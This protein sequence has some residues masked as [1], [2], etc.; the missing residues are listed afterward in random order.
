MKDLS[1]CCPGVDLLA[2][3]G[4][5]H[6][7]RTSCHKLSNC[8]PC[9]WSIDLQD[10]HKNKWEITKKNTVLVSMNLHVPKNLLVQQRKH[11]SMPKAAYAQLSNT[12]WF[13]IQWFEYLWPIFV[14][15]HIDNSKIVQGWTKTMLHIS[16]TFS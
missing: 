5:H 3:M 6:S 9:K 8:F 4:R 12:K 2:C 15:T 7:N 13:A 14:V 16:T 10:A 1:V 11:S